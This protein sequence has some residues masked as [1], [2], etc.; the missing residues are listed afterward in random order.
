MRWGNERQNFLCHCV[1]G[2]GHNGCRS[3]AHR[4]THG[5]PCKPQLWQRGGGF[6]E[7]PEPDPDEFGTTAVTISQATSSG[8]GFSISGVSLP[9]TLDAGQSATF[10][11]SLAPTTA[12]S[13][14]GTATIRS[15]QLSAPVSIA[16]T[17]TGVAVAPSITSQP[18]S[19]GIL[20]NQTATFSVIAAGTAPLSYQWKKTGV[21]IS[22]ATS[23][24]Y[25]T[26]AEALSGNGT[27]FTVVVTNAAGS[28]TSNA[29]TLTVTTAPVAPSITTQPANQTTT[30]GLT[31]TFADGYSFG[32][33][34]T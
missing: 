19:E 18:A 26:P 14:S 17:G 31:A 10:T 33:G 3:G 15:S 32:H 4:S 34:S 1:N 30:A 22:G 28:A 25:T 13:A 7:Q 24:S 12:G 8:T 16:M 6:D 11:A 20:V 23:A 5:E 9:V 27:Q 21:A 2:I 29:A